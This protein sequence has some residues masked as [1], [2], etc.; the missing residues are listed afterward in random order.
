[1][2]RH[3]EALH[4]VREAEAQ[5]K[6]QEV[7][8]ASGLSLEDTAERIEDARQA[9]LHDVSLFDAPLTDKGKIQAREAGERLKKLVED[10]TI[11]APTEAMVSPLS[12]CLETASIILQQKRQPVPILKAHIRHELRERQTQFPPDKARPHDRL[13]RWTEYNERFVINQLALTDQEL[14]L[15]ESRSMLR[16]R[17]SKLFDSLLEMEH[18]HILI[19]SHKGYLREMERGLLG[20]GDSPMFDNAE[21][22][23]YRV[24][25]TRGERALESVERLA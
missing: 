4:N 3:G 17:A 21:L 18:R 8:K 9:V 1:M 2:I 15:E 10:G 24:T 6:A 19:V 12:R 23:V 14:A 25:F 20:L 13:L 11:P 22:R 7:A 5:Q 16:E